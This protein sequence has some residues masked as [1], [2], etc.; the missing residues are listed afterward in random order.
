MLLV[1]VIIPA[2]QHGQC[3]LEAVESVI[4]QTFRDFEVIVINDGCTD[5][6][7]EVLRPFV[8][9]KLIR[10]FHQENQGISATRNRGL[11]LALGEFVA[12]LDDD[13]VWP[14]DKLE[15]QVYVLRNSTVLVVGGLASVFGK[16]G[17]RKLIVETADY[18]TIDTVTLFGGN[19]FG[20]PGQTLIR[21]SALLEIG[22]FDPTIWGADD[23][24]VW[25]RL[26]RMGEIRRY[27]RISLMY[28]VHD[29]NTSRDSERMFENAEKVIRKNLV[30]VS[31]GERVRLER[32]GFRFLF[33]YGGKKLF[34]KGMKLICSGCFRDGWALIGRM[35]KM[36]YPVAL[37]DPKLFL[38]LIGAILK[39]PWKMWRT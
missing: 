37:S 30:D 16:K 4:A 26:S 10:Y 12:F 9:K 8:E 25:I 34:W 27:D 22:G 17:D 35:L 14:P 3:I 6:T 38:Q 1:S 20:S 11:S 5:N 19:P 32:Q 7:E 28:R 39:S 36:F 31:E 21:K 24:D 2:Y 15:W 23:H 29:S 13:D 18:S 33:R